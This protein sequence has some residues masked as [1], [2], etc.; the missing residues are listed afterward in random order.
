MKNNKCK[1]HR[2]TLF[3]IEAHT[4]YDFRIKYIS[5]EKKVT[6]KKPRTVQTY[7]PTYKSEYKSSEQIKELFLTIINSWIDED[8]TLLIKSNWFTTFLT[9][10]YVNKAFTY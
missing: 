3:R 10:T 5:R 6:S 9:S 7:I 2:L 8:E 1:L 4:I